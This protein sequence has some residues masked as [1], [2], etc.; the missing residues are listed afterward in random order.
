MCFDTRSQ[1]ILKNYEDNLESEINYECIVLFFFFIHTAF[2]RGREDYLLY[3]LSSSSRLQWNPAEG[4]LWNNPGPPPHVERL[5]FH[6]GNIEQNMI[7]TFLLEF[8]TRFSSTE[9]EG[10]IILLESPNQSKDLVDELWS[11]ET[12]LIAVSDLMKM[13]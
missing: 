2:L 10:H 5:K 3:M 6:D 13:W 12:M 11:G 8:L 1:W 9:N 4:S 7:Y